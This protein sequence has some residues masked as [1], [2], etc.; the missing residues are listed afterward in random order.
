MTPKKIIVLESENNTLGSQLQESLGEEPQTLLFIERDLR[1]FEARTVQIQPDLALIAA[2]DTGGDLLDLTH[3]LSSKQPAP[4]IILC[5]EK[6]DNAS[7][8]EALR[9]GVNDVL[10]IP[11]TNKK[12]FAIVQRWL[13][14]SN[15]PATQ[16]IPPMQVPL[17]PGKNN[18]Y[19]LY[20]TILTGLNDGVLVLDYDHRII[21]VNPKAQ[22]LFNLDGQGNRPQPVEELIDN[23]DLLV[24]IARGITDQPFLGEVVLGDMRVMQ[25]QVSPLSGLGMVITLQDITHLKELD[26]IKNEFVSTVSHDLRSPLTA[27]LGYTE[28]IARVGPTNARQNEFISRVQLSVNNI[29]ALIDDLLDLGRIEAGFDAQKSRVAVEEILG[30]VVDSYKGRIQDNNQILTLQVDGDLTPIIG[31]MI[32][33]RQMFN[34]LIG[35]AIKYTP[36]EGQIKVLA[37]AEQE[38]VFVQISDSGQGIPTPDL[39]YIFDKFYRASNIPVD[40]PGTGLGLT[41]VKTIVENHNGRIWAE[42]KPDHGATFTVVFP[43]N[44]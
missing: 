29:T 5:L 10:H 3:R 4:S 43:T 18:G 27:I 24:L 41:I 30:L 17:K 14:G 42:S 28:L 34:N 16:I 22:E 37:W 9:A 33:L 13:N 36:P 38:Q 11:C 31:N 2:K 23:N 12:L 21:F 19:H 8:K 1:S 26:R 39:P 35:N 25:A 32:H 44:N 7:K 40:I 6:L 15:Q 20:E